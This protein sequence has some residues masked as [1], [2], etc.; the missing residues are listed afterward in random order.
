MHARKDCKIAKDLNALQN[1]THCVLVVEDEFLI[2]FMIADYLTECGFLVLEASTADD[3]LVLLETTPVDVVFSDVNMPG[4]M[5]GFDLACWIR[6]N[7]PETSVLLASGVA[8]KANAVAH[9]LPAESLMEKPYDVRHVA[10]HIQ[11]LV[12]AMH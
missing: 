11:C 1:S 2:R 12:E 3:A 7:R 9:G 6:A 10:E 5:D 4:R 8:R